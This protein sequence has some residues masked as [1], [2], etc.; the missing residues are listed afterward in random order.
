MEQIII[1]SVLELTVNSKSNPFIC[2]DCKKP[3]ELMDDRILC[4]NQWCG[5]YVVFVRLKNDS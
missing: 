2:P 3:L 5:R 1:G 4:P